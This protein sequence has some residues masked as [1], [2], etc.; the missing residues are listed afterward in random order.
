MIITDRYSTVNN[1]ILSVAV[2]DRLKSKISRILILFA[3]IGDKNSANS[4]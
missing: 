2:L 3:S 1:A 4:C